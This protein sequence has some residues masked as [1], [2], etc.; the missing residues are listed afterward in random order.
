MNVFEFAEKYKISVP[1]VRKIAKDYPALFDDGDNPLIDEIRHYLGRGQPLSAA[2]LCAIV[3]NRGI[4]LALGRYADRAESQ[5]QELGKFQQ[6]IAPCEISSIISDAAKGDEDA[7]QSLTEWLCKIIPS[8]PV[9]HSYIAVRLLLGVPENIRKYEVPRIPLAM[10]QCRNR[11][12]F[13]KW[14]R[15][16]KIGGRNTTIYQQPKK[17]VAN[18]DL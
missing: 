17:S 15:V 4:L 7:V 16:E 12:D 10:L 6:E 11:G 14:W 8:K 5:V 9:A 3:E 1:K 2:Q 13:A 18:F